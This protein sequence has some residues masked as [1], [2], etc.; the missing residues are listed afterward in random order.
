M[1]KNFIIVLALIQVVFLI[2]CTNK[3]NE[4]KDSS[5]I[6]YSYE[7]AISR[8]DVVN[9]EHN[10]KNFDRFLMS[11][12]NK[13]EDTVRITNYTDEGDPIYT[14]LSYDGNIINYLYD[15]SNDK[16]GAEN[17]GVK[18]DKCKEIVTNQVENAVQYVISGCENPENNDAVLFHM[19][20]TNH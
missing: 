13:K 16:F 10:I 8:G 20:T 1:N 17:K 12:T 7:E 19:K 4:N 14:E 2:G 6:S 15:N 5:I 18:T 9:G 3:I 11:L